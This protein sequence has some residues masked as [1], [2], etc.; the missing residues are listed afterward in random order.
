MSFLKV[1]LVET[2]RLLHRTQ[3]QVTR[4]TGTQPADILSQHAASRLPDQPG[5]LRNWR[6]PRRIST[7]ALHR[8]RHGARVR[9]LGYS[10]LLAMTW[11]ISGCAALEAI[12]TMPTHALPTETPPPSPTFAWFPPSSTPTAQVFLSPLPTP[13][14]R[15]GLGG[16]TQS[17]DL[18]DPSTWTTAASDQASA[19]IENGRLTLAVKSQVYMTSLRQDLFFGDAYVEITALP[20]LC[21]GEDSYGM[22]FRANAVAGYR[23]SLYCNGQV[24]VERVSVGKRQVLQEPMPSGD[25][26]PGAPGVVRIGVWAAGTEMRLFLNDRYQ[27]SVIDANY[28][29]GTVGVFLNSAGSTAATVSFADLVVQDI[30]YVPPIGTPEP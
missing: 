13:E 11:L 28:A 16:I 8:T 6:S 20:G 22:L 1:L 17:D 7:P 23:F 5:P 9:P 29:S 14:M 15:H 26:P 12:I 27:F 2:R 19:V 25:V 10:T 24:G 4:C 18:S 30:L 21:R 3:V